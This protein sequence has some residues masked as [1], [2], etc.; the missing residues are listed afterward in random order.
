MT[1][2]IDHLGPQPK[3]IQWLQHIAYKE[4]FRQGFGILLVGWLA[5]IATKHPPVWA[6]VPL[7]LIGEVIRFYAAGFVMKNEVLATHGPYAGVRHPLYLGNTLVLLG[8]AGLT[9]QV[10]TFLPTFGFLLLFYPAAID[11]EDRKLR[12]LFG[13]EWDEWRNRT[14]AMFPLIR[15]SPKPAE[16]G[17]WSLRVAAGRNGEAYILIYVLICLAFATGLVPSLS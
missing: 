16:P 10:W 6:F 3:L 13:T 15:R 7:I 8:F 5:Y 9:G 2:R 14:P 17:Q 1:H 4:I 11:Y 12:R